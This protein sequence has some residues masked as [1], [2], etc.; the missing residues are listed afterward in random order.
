MLARFFAERAREPRIGGAPN[1]GYSNAERPPQTETRTMRRIPTLA[2][3]I[4]LAG[5][6]PLLVC[7]LAGLTANRAWAIPALIAYGAVVLS[8]GGAV[9]WGMAFGPAATLEAESRE[10]ARLVLGVVPAA[11]GW[12]ALLLPLPLGLAALIAGFVVTLAGEIAAD[13]HNLLPRHYLWLRWPLSLVAIAMITTDLV[14]TL[15]GATIAL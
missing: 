9:H 12:V 4:S 7:G 15:L 13:R 8:F 2:I 1:P 3:L 10:R 6:V 5:L 11:I 14:L